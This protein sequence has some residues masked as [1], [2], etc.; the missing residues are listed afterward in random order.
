MISNKGKVV[1]VTLAEPF[2]FG[3][4]NGRWNHALVKGLVESGYKVRCLSLEWDPIWAQ[5]AQKI[6]GANVKLSFYRTTSNGSEGSWSRKWQTMRQPFSYLLPDSLKKDFDAEIKKG[7]DVLH[8]EQFWSGY[9][10]HGQKCCLTSIH[11]LQRLDLFRLRSPSWPFFFSKIMMCWAERRLVQSLQHI[12]TTTSRLTDAVKVINP[13]A[14]VYTVPIALDPSLF[15]FKREDRTP[16]P[17]IGFIA[18]MNWTPGY[19]A[20]ERMITRI[21]PLI[22]A[23]KPDARLLL[24]GWNA[25]KALAG[26]LE[27]PGVQ[28]IE[29]VPEAKPYFRKLR[30][31]AYPL[32]QGSGMMAKVLEA[33]AYG[34]PVVTTTEGMEGISGE[35]GS[36]AFIADDDEL[37]AD[38][39]I[40][41]LDDP[42]LRQRLRFNA[43]Q[44][45]ED[46][47]SPGPAVCALEHVYQRL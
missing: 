18:S 11:H 21:F 32:P 42:S 13:K 20:A 2:P 44:L 24:V 25:R 3:E 46:R 40:Q 15:E 36:H 5:G 14:F 4:A 34:I 23:K 43:R 28:V 35:N 17:V 37:F 16:E 22:Q 6:F 7:Y 12:R 27:T 33:M 8:L 31:F 9:L 47:Y 19:L 1:L 10:A 26:Y 45:I 38:R 30:V 29:N 39:V 41:L